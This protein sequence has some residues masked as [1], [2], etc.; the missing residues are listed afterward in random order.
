MLSRRTKLRIA[1][2]AETISPELQN[3]DGITDDL[4]QSIMQDLGSMAKLRSTGD[5]IYDVETAMEWADLV[6]STAKNIQ[7]ATRTLRELSQHM[8]N[9]PR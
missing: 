8:L 2:H 4:Y 1:L 6:E 5:K 9:D 3:L 7:E